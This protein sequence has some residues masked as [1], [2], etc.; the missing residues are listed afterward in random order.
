LLYFLVDK[1]SFEKWGKK[2]EEKRPPG[3]VGGG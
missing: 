3:K 1:K 2:R